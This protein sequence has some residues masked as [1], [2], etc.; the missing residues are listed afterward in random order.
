[1]CEKQ[2]IGKQRIRQY[3]KIATAGMSRE[4]WLLLR[5]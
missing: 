1:M 2:K 5:E 3:E 4:E